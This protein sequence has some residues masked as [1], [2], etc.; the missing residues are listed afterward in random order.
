MSDQKKKNGKLF[1]AVAG[2]LAVAILFV[3]VLQVVFCGTIVNAK[4]KD[5]T[6]SQYL[7]FAHSYATTVTTELEK[8]FASLDFYVYSDPITNGASNAEIV[9]WLREHNYMRS[10]IFDYVAWVDT[11][12]NFDSDIGTHTNVLDRDYYDA[13]VNKGKK[14]FIDNPVSSKTSGKTIVHICRGVR[15]NGEVIGFFCGVVQREHIGVLLK[16]IDV[17]N[18]GVATLIDGNGKLIASS[19]KDE[20]MEQL[21]QDLSEKNP[22]AFETLNKMWTNSQKDS[23]SI[24]NAGGED[25]LVITHPVENTLWTITLFLNE[26]QVYGISALIQKIMFVGALVMTVFV[27][28]VLCTV[29]YRMIK[30][31]KVV[32]STILGIS[33]GDADLTRRIN[34]K[35][36]NEIGR[37]V[38]GFNQFSEKMQQII[39]TLKSSKDRLEDVGQLLHDS[40]D[41]TVSAI[42]QI[43]ANIQSMN[44]QVVAQSDSV[45]QTAGAVNQIAAN[46]ESLNRMIESQT[47]AVS[48]ASSAVEE[49]IGNI[50]SVNSSVQKMADAFS[51]LEKKAIIG[52][53]KQND[54]NSKIVEI[55][56]E[57][58]ALQEANVVISGIAEQTNLLAMNAAIE[59]AHAG[60]AGKGFSVVADEIR[61]LSEDSG[62]QSQTI[63]NQLEKIIA[64]IE[65]IVEASMTA[66]EAFN[67]VS[68]GIN[69]T[70]N[71][72]REISNAMTEQNEGSKQIAIALNSMNDTSN[73]VRTSSFEMAEGNKAILEE[74]KTL[75]DA[76][77]NIRNGMDEMSAGARKINETSASLAEISEQMKESIN[78]IGSQVDQFKV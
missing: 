65:Q 41:D 58:Q 77:F 19:V 40:T 16:G 30:P 70:N 3:N 23:V 43:I 17:E 12:G 63:G 74:I 60:E 10:G 51:E 29:L 13:I 21:I 61:K 55:Q 7:E 26:K 44:G 49:M 35:S 33:S 11:E 34:L 62:A 25:Q 46:I 37:V 56:T 76:S 45:N 22:S 71:L 52:V 36:N 50:N 75:Q 5:E 24:K 32:E 2:I 1:I 27:I 18:I 47:T 4:I 59:A 15:R 69:S 31:L 73:E 54:V 42:T 20:E 48:Q 67:E 14:T 28:L 78:M 8:Y 39:S 72:V 53:Q 64:S 9:K 68:S 66:T 57:S 38:D 6:Q